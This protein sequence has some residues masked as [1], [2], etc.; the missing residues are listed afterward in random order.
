MMVANRKLHRSSSISN[1][2]PTL[3]RRHNENINT[4][5]RQLP[6]VEKVRMIQIESEWDI[7]G[8]SLF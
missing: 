6:K 1:P 5:L 3:V 8:C 7:Q 4:F 2:R